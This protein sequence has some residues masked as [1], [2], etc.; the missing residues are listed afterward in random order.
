MEPL[1]TIRRI[2]CLDDP[3]LGPWLDLKNAE[4]T[5][6]HMWDESVVGVKSLDPATQVIRF[7]NPAGHPPGAFGVHNYV[8]WNVREGMTAPGQWYL[9]RTAG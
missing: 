4:I 7:A 2:T 9:D 8:V 5:V 6:Y 3:L 1:P